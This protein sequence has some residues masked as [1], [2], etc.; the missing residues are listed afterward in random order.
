[1][2]MEKGKAQGKGH[3]NACGAPAPARCKIHAIHQVIS[4]LQMSPAGTEVRQPPFLEDCFRES[5][6]TWYIYMKD[7]NQMHFIWE[8]A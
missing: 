5:R 3:L 6:C 4:R 2:H 8:K 1:M 7:V